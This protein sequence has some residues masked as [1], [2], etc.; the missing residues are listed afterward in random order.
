MAFEV[1]DGDEGLVEAEGEGF[2]VGDADEEGAGEAGAVGDGD[3]VEVAAVGDA[4]SAHGGADDGDDV[5]EV[6]A[7]GEFGDDAA[8]VGV[9]GDLRGD[10]VRE[11]FAAGADDGGGGLVAGAFD[12]EDEAG[13]RAR[14]SIVS[15]VCG[16]DS[17]GTRTRGVEMMGS[18]SGYGCG[19]R[20]IVRAAARS[21]V[22]GVLRRRVRARLLLGVAP[23]DFDVAT[24][25]PP[26]D[27]AGGCFARDLAVGAHFGVVLV[28]DDGGRARGSRPRWRRFGM[29]GLTAMGGGRMR[30]GFRGTRA[31]MCCGGTSR[32]T[33]CCWMSLGM[34]RGRRWRRVLDFVGGRDDLQAGV[35]R[36]IGEPVRRFEEDKLRM[37]RAVRFAA[38]LSLRSSARRSRR[39]Q[40][41][42]PEI[43]Q[44]SRRAGAG[45]VDEDADRRAGARRGFELLDETGLLVQVL[46]E[47]ARMKGVEQPPEYHP[48]GDVWVHTLMLLEKLPA[49]CAA[50]AG[51]GD[52]AARCGQAGDVYA[53]GAGDRIRFNGH[54]EVGM[55]M[56]RGDPERRLRFSNEETAQI[57]SLVENHMRFGDVKKMKQSTLKRFLRLP[58]L[59]STWRCTAGCGRRVQRQAGAV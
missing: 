30:C 56:A 41:L 19:V 7:G 55:R 59:R 10:D 27:G 45:G 21:G 25:R 38:R 34:R 12:A 53:D 8:V 44:V 47:V 54:V 14:W 2:G 57:L 33:G 22:S 17:T 37:L 16:G 32:S 42:A 1:V 15:G 26:D 4:G 52:A 50:D 18:A 6:L 9:D 13:C 51:L 3:G 39:S 20:R 28:F 23:K 24:M 36:A 46:P 35:V 31:R 43:G 11:D 48:E 49:G 5:A 58:R 40:A 29:M